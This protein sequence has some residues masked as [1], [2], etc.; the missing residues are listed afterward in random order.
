MN[1]IGITI[2]GATPSVRLELSNWLAALLSQAGHAITM[3][4]AVGYKQDVCH[5]S[6]TATHYPENLKEIMAIN[7]AT[8]VR[9]Y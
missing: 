1:T 4:H 6:E 7:I 3:Q 5:L 9:L 2:A 8:N